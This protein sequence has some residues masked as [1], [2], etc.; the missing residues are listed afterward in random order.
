M[1]LHTYNIIIN[2]QAA[3]R[4]ILVPNGLVNGHCKSSGDARNTLTS[5]T[6]QFSQMY[7]RRPIQNTNNNLTQTHH[8]VAH[9]HIMFN[10]HTTNHCN[11]SACES[12]LNCQCIHSS[13]TLC[14]NNKFVCIT[15]GVFLSCS[16]NRQASFLSH[17]P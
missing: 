14:L 12:Y 13:A 6:S 5:Y 3:Q 15:G 16:E 2:S 11:M 10:R 1:I 4:D 9:T 8:S 17:I 7:V